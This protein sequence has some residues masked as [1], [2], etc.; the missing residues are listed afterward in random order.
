MASDV[1]HRYATRSWPK[2]LG[3]RL[4]GSL[5]ALLGIIP[6]A[7]MPRNRIGP[8]P[9]RFAADA[10]NCIMVRVSTDP[11]EYKVVAR[12][13]PSRSRAP[14]GSSRHRERSCQSHSTTQAPYKGNLPSL[15]P[16]TRRSSGISAY[17][18]EHRCR[19]S[20]VGGKA[21]VPAT[22]PGNPLVAKKATFCSCVNRWFTIYVSCPGS[23]MAT[24]LEGPP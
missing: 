10:H 4:Y 16:G 3:S 8:P 22:W 14:L 24:N 20:P 21:D 9:R 15:L 11:S 5:S 19:M 12:A 6:M 17:I 23:C 13:D 1:P 7:F 2:A 18:S